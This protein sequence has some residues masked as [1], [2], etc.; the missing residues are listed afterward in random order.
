MHKTP[1]IYLAGPDVFR[2]DAM[3]HGEELKK[4]CASAGF[5]G[6]FPADGD[7]DEELKGVEKAEAIYA[8]NIRLIQEADLVIANISPFRGPGMDAGTAFEIGFALALRMPVIGYATKLDDYADRVPHRLNAEENIRI[9]E[10]GM[11]VEDFGLCENLMIA[12]GA[13]DIVGSFDEALEAARIILE[14]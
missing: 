5:E 7:I 11:I 12:I 3:E 6:L 13:D 1:K 9:A 10:D 4:K 8:D 2:Q 14:R